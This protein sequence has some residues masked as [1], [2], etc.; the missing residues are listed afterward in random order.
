LRRLLVTSKAEVLES[1]RLLHGTLPRI[2][3]KGAHSAECRFARQDIF[4]DF[5]YSRINNA[6]L[7]ANSQDETDAN[8]E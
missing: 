3:K 4:L 5:P 7:L 2:Q 6:R 8:L 1:V